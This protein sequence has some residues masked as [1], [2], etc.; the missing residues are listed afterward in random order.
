M[1]INSLKELKKLILLCRQTGVQ[2]M[3]IDGIELHLGTLPKQTVR[4]IDT[5]VFP[6]ESI[7]VPAYTPVIEDDGKVDEETLTDEQLLFYS[8]RS[9]TPEQTDQ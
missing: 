5:N 2:S 1:V 3:K 8:S 6:E 7:K 4:S 9:D